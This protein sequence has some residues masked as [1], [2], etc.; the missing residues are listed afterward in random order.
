MSAAVV[1]VSDLGFFNADPSAN[2]VAFDPTDFTATS[3]NDMFVVAYSG[4]QQAAS[5][6]LYNGIA[7]TGTIDGP[8]GVLSDTYIFFWLNPT[9]GTGVLTAD[10]ERS[11]R[12][13]FMR[14]FYLDN[15]AQTAPESFD[16][17]TEPNTSS[18]LTLGSISVTE[19]AF[20]LD[21]FGAN[22]SDISSGGMTDSLFFNSGSNERNG[23]SWQ[24]ASASDAA[25]GVSSTWNY[26]SGAGDKAGVIASFQ[27]VAIP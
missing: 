7:P 19:G 23:S 21:S 20:V 15:V 14:A 5:N 25:S 10:T 13:V 2:S 11:D 9:V 6:V 12:F 16:T 18:T 27:P 8:S 1:S 17:T 22:N 26:G 24:I 4:K 3:T